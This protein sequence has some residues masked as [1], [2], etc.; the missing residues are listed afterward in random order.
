MTNYSLTFIHEKKLLDMITTQD[1]PKNTKILAETISV[2][3]VW[4]IPSDNR[5]NST[6]SQGSSVIYTNRHTY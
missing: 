6:T 3:S 1:S 2:C 4:C 5:T